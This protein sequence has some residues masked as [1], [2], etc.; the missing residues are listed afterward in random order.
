[1]RRATAVN[2]T[3]S[4][5]EIVPATVSDEADIEAWASGSDTT[6]RLVR[7]I[8]AGCIAV[9]ELNAWYDGR[10]MERRLVKQIDLGLAVDT[11][12]GLSSR[13]CAMSAAGMPP[14]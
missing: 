6:I 5:A 9:P 8:M 1:V 3:R 11:G 10:N 4:H 13:C 14:I 12:G 2:M 7:A